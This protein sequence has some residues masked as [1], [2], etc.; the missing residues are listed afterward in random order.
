MMAT[1]I[2]TILYFLNIKAAKTRWKEATPLLNVKRRIPDDRTA[3]YR[4][5]VKI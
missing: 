5:L 3:C 2:Q 1:T 4:R